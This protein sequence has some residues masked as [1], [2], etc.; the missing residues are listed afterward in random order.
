M[1]ALETEDRLG[2]PSMTPCWGV[3]SWIWAT[4]KTRWALI[5][6]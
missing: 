6:G 3:R 2:S 5:W 4:V 1:V